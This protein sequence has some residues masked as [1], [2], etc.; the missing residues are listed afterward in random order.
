MFFQCSPT[1]ASPYSLFSPLFTFVIMSP[2]PF[3]YLH[4][5]SGGAYCSRS[6]KKTHCLPSDIENISHNSILN[7]YFLAQRPFEKPMKLQD[8]PP[9]QSQHSITYDFLHETYI[10][11]QEIHEPFEN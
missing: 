8:H 10:E 2:P 1:L 3:R 6:P 9:P 5:I 11:F 7:L 4:I